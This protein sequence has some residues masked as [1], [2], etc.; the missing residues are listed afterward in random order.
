MGSQSDP[1]HASSYKKHAAIPQPVISQAAMSA[2]SSPPTPTTAT[3]PVIPLSSL[4][5]QM[6]LTEKISKMD[7]PLTRVATKQKTPCKKG[8]TLSSKSGKRE[9]TTVFP[10]SPSVPSTYKKT[11]AHLTYSQSES[12]SD[13]SNSQTKDGKPTQKTTET[14]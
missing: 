13:N 3:A 14:D 1:S 10:T 5:P 2:M 8:A 11:Q 12:S 4:P 6:T 9:T 7:Q